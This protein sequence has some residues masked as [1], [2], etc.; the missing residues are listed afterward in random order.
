M[1]DFRI[2]TLTVCLPACLPV[3]LCDST[4]NTSLKI[5]QIQILLLQL[6]LR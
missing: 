1:L 3:C 6:L 4:Y 5:F 2:Q